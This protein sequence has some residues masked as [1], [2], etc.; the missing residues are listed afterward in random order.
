LSPAGNAGVTTVEEVADPR[1]KIERSHVDARLVTPDS[2]KW[3]VK[4]LRDTGALQSLVSSSVA[5]NE[6]IIIIFPVNID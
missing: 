4:I 2:S 3:F 5:S 6:E 1:Y